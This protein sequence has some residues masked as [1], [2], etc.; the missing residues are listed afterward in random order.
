MR[1]SV[2]VSSEAEDMASIRSLGETGTNG[3]NELAMGDDL[4]YDPRCSSEPDSEILPDVD[5]EGQ[6]EQEE[7]E[8]E[9]QSPKQLTE[10]KSISV[11]GDSDYKSSYLSESEN[12]NQHAEDLSETALP[13]P[14]GSPS[15]HQ[16]SARSSH[17]TV[18]CEQES[19]KQESSPTAGVPEE[20]SK[21]DSDA[22][23]LQRPKQ[24]PHLASPNQEILW[25]R[26]DEG[27]AT[28]RAV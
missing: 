1:D 24:S 13:L 9:E 16:D 26:D 27:D 15:Q 3:E 2:Q 12:L 18:E 23:N 7:Q 14:P 11:I 25:R 17:M 4:A 6:G 20:T 19:L 10:T 21:H 22:I 5:H 28:E 8:Q